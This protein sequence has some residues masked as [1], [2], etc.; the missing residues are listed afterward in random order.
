MNTSDV[1]AGI[2]SG[3]LLTFGGFLTKKYFLPWLRNLITDSLDLTGKWH[4]HFTSPAGSLHEVTMTLKHR[5]SKLAGDMAIIKYLRNTKIPEIKKYS[6]NGELRTKFVI[7]NAHNIKK[8][9][10]GAHTE[11]LEII[12]GKTL[13]GVGLWFSATDKIIQSLQ[14]EWNRI[15]EKE[16]RPDTHTA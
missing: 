14:F 11:L 7:L 15:G 10:M 6:V 2:I 4:C 9:A 1:L 3:I 5:G 8:Q 13:K 12:D 16:T